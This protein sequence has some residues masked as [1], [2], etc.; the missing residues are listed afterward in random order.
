MNSLLDVAPSTETVSVRN[1]AVAITGVSALGIASLMRRFPKIRDLF[2]GS[3]VELN[4]EV[5]L[6]LGPAVVAAVIAAGTGHPGDQKHEE[7][8]A[9]FP[10]MSQIKLL[11]AILKETFPDGLGKAVALLT[12]LAASAGLSQEDSPQPSSSS[13]PRVTRM[14]LRT[15]PAASPSSQPS[16]AAGAAAS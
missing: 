4:A 10:A 5:L 1:T 14:P 7:A 3:D 11:T 16:P 15:P 9:G 2:S 13:S 12:D 8:A 6:E